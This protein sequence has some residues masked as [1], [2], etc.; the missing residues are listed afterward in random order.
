M[1]SVRLNIPVSTL[2]CASE[3][4][5]LPMLMS[6]PKNLG[7][8]PTSASTPN[9]PPPIVAILTPKLA[10]LG[11]PLISF[12]DSA[13]ELLRLAPR[14]GVNSVSAPARDAVITN[15]ITMSARL[16]DRPVGMKWI[17]SV[18]RGTDP[19]KAEANRAAQDSR[20]RRPERRL[21]RPQIVTPR[22]HRRGRTPQSPRAHR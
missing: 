5:T 15:A 4:G 6:V 3:I 17:S 22:I 11:S 13:G 7:A 21:L 18:R 20:A 8:Y 9:T 19:Y 16:I 1:P 2:L 14:N 10:R 12:G